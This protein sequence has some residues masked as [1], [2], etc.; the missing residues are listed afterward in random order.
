MQ[1]FLSKFGYPLCLGSLDGT[2]IQIK[3]PLG[4]EPDYY[5]YKKHHSVRG[6]QMSA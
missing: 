6:G 1:G 5:N 4:A 2:H 3:A